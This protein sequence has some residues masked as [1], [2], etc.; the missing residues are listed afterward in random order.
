MKKYNS[1]ALLLFLFCFSIYLPVVHSQ[2]IPAD[3]HPVTVVDTDVQPIVTIPD[4]AQ[5]ILDQAGNPLSSTDIDIIN[6]FVSATVTIDEANQNKQ[7]FSQQI[8]RQNSVLYLPIEIIDSKGIRTI[9]GIYS[10]FIDGNVA[11]CLLPP[12]DKEFNI[13]SERYTFKYNLQDIKKCSLP[14]SN[15][16]CCE[17]TIQLCAK[18]LFGK[19]E[20]PAFTFCY[21]SPGSL[22][23]SIIN[24]WLVRLDIG[25][26]VW[27]QN[28]RCNH[29]ERICEPFTAVTLASF[30]VNP[31]NKAATLTWETGDETN[32]FGFN[33]YRSE[34]KNNVFVKI[35]KSVIPS[36][37]VSGS[38]AMYQ[39][40]DEN[41]KNGKTYFY[42]IEDID[43]FGNSVLH[44][45]D[46]KSATPLLIYKIIQ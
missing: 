19:Q 8:M 15:Y 40:S 9:T 18:R 1:I 24:A 31:G 5:G 29:E 2:D 32:N 35:N 41:L 42:M 27:T 34:S 39:Y 22:L 26:T 23:C 6:D 44:E 30:D 11:N 28:G 16:G 25:Y 36:Q 45:N 14:D 33:I 46:I 17:I 13:G 37:A 21:N 43:L 3:A 7:A 12:A 4:G 38:G 10:S 20:I